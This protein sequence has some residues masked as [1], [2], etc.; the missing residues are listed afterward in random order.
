MKTLVRLGHLL[1]VLLMGTACPLSL[2]AG[3]WYVATNGSDT[4]NSGSEDSPFATVQRAVNAAAEGDLILVGPGTYKLETPIVVPSDKSVSIRATAYP[5]YT[6]TILDG[7]GKSACVAF[8]KQTWQTFSGFTVSNCV[9]QLIGNTYYA[10]IYAAGGSVYACHVTDC[11]V[12]VEAGDVAYDISG[13]GVFV[14]SGSAQSLVVDN[15]TISNACTSASPGNVSG[16]GI[17]VSGGNVEDCV[18][19]NC[20][21]WCNIPNYTGSHPLKGS[22]GGILLNCDNRATHVQDCVVSGCRVTV[23]AKS[24]A[25]GTGGGVEVYGKAIVT[26][27]LIEGNVS[28]G[29]GGGFHSNSGSSIYSST[30]R[31]N[32]VFALVRD[33]ARNQGGGILLSSNTEAVNCEI[34]GNVCTNKI[35]HGDPAGGGGIALVSGVKVLDCRIDGNVALNGGALLW[36]VDNVLVSNCTLT[37]NHVL[38]RGGAI[39]ATASAGGLLTDCVIDRNSCVPANDGLFMTRHAEGVGGTITIRNS[40]ISN[41]GNSGYN[42]S[43][44]WFYKN[45][46]TGST[47][48]ALDHCTIVGNRCCTDACALFSLS[49]AACKTMFTVKGCVIAN[50]GNLKTT[51]VASGDLAACPELVTYSYCANATGVPTAVESHNLFDVDPLFVDAAHGDYRLAQGSP[52]VD[53]GGP[54]QDWMGNGRKKGP[55]DMGDGTLTAVRQVGTDYGVTLVRN[56]AKPRFS[57]DFPDMGCFEF[58]QKPGA[59]LF[60]R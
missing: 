54:R 23:S 31:S 9:G 5:D 6:Q 7:Q 47:P 18:V 19:S 22:G 38:R 41:H 56:E 33:T 48:I 52:L 4:D 12:G 32:E 45:T 34:V 39:Y 14:S 59:L 28:T 42:M 35:A 2:S 13:A 15:C 58:W 55:L 16:G 51:N 11:H 37:A 24:L 27:C 49:G 29:A 44:L 25:C 50:N 26:N 1:P 40:V 53:V 57:G 10:A 3:E 8:R 36:T 17:Y 43:V 60:F 21:V 20:Q 30:V 46:N